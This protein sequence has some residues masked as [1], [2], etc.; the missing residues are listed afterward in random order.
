MP[1][2]PAM[3]TMPTMPTMPPAMMPNTISDFVFSRP[4]LEA[5]QLALARA[6][7]VEALTSNGPFTL[8]APNNDAFNTVPGFFL[9]LLFVNDEFIPHLQN[10][11]LFHLLFGEASSVELENLAGA[12]GT[13]LAALSLEMVVIQTNNLTINGVDLIEKDNDVE[14]G[15]VHIIDEVL[16]PSWVFNSITGRVAGDSDT[17]ILFTLL[18]LA[19]IDLTIPSALTLVAPTNDAFNALPDGAIDFLTNPDNADELIII[20][21]YHVINGVFVLTELQDGLQLPTVLGTT[22]VVVSIVDETVFFNQAQN[23]ELDILANN[24]VV[25]KISAVLNPANSPTRR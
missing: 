5:L 7:F 1:T 9:E 12:T 16:A 14:N 24:G 22:S 23:L 15:I 13:N 21:A 4:D 11:L 20:L 17:S 19:G 10:L 25:L 2:M 6:G 18:G 3:P 8:F